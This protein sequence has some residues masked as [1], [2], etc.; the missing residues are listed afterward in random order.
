MHK[1]IL[2]LGAAYPKCFIFNKD[3]YI[4]KLKLNYLGDHCRLGKAI[5]SANKRVQESF[6]LLVFFVYFL[7]VFKT[8]QLNAPTNQNSFKVPKF[9]KQTNTKT[10]L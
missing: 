6:F 2:E 1:V 5:T 10:L 4:H 3:N 7:L 8:T 9:V